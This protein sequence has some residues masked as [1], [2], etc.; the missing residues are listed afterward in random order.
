[1]R[2]ESHLQR[3]VSLHG[4]DKEKR[5]NEVRLTRPKLVTWET[6]TIYA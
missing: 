2:S 6:A 4:L 5:S 3:E 1:M